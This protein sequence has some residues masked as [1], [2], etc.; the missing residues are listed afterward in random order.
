M[1][2]LEQR[3]DKYRSNVN[4]KLLEYLA[5]ATG[6]NEN[7]L[8]KLNVGFD[9][10]EQAIIFTERDPNG[11]TIYLVRWF[12]DDAKRSLIADEN[13]LVYI[14]NKDISRYVK[15]KI[16][17]NLLWHPHASS[18]AKQWIKEHWIGENG[19]LSA[20]YY[21]FFRQDVLNNMLWN[22][23]K[24]RNYIDKRWIQDPFPGSEPEEEVLQI[25]ICRRYKPTTA[26]IKNIR[27]CLKFEV[28][29]VLEKHTT[30]D[31]GKGD[32]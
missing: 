26:K 25:A 6:V 21:R 15:A 27:W 8:E 10:D 7:D 13:E 1:V 2:E 24:D 16:A 17:G 20:G 3:F 11:R 19:K 4:P 28:Q 18:I 22:W 14:L 9:T 32:S 12:R 23:L 29:R 30:A 5:K 31:A